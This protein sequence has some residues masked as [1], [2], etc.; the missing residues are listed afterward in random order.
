M[1]IRLG[2]VKTDIEPRHCTGVIPFFLNGSIRSWNDRVS[3]IFPCEY[4]WLDVSGGDVNTPVSALA[5]DA[6]SSRTVVSCCWSSRGTE[7]TL[8]HPPC[9]VWFVQNEPEVASSGF[10]EIFQRMSLHFFG[11]SGLN[12]HFIVSCSNAFC[13]F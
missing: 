12:A 11:R 4:Q 6:N 7:T 8:L 13:A 2:N 10:R 9:A 1:Q 5:S 3:R